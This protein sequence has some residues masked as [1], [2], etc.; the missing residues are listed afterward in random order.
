M[1]TS[2]LT[3]ILLLC[4]AHPLFATKYAE[5][6]L[7]DLVKISEYILAGDVVNVRM[8]DK[9]GK[10]ITDPEA[11]TGPGLENTIY[12]DVMVDHKLI[13]KSHFSKIPKEISIPLDPM[14]HMSLGDSQK[15]FKEK[16]FFFLDKEFHPA[17]PGNF[18]LPID[19]QK[20]LESI[21]RRVGTK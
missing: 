17:H 3:T 6:S 2:L 12:L 5:I 16:S 13:L 4:L 7:P 18:Q 9:S 20:K 15:Y 21:I 10:E 11:R 1:K 19:E 8:V 14:R